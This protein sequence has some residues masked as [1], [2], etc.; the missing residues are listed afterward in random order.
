MGL[1]LAY[2]F[3]P[4]YQLALQYKSDVGIRSG[5]QNN[6]ILARFLWATDLKG[7][8]GGEKK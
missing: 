3:A 4:G 6:V 1:T 8:F 5:T 2:S 7:L